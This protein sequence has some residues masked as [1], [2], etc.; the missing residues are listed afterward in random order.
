MTFTDIILKNPEIVSAVIFLLFAIPASIIDARTKKIPD[1][2]NLFGIVILLCYRFSV[3]KKEALVYIM[4][5]I[6][7]FLLLLTVR[8][9]TKK[10]LG[11]GDAK[12]GALCA[13]Y[14]GPIAVF[15]GF[16]LAAIFAGIFYA[17]KRKSPSYKKDQAFPF[18]LFL[19]AGTFISSL[20]SLI[21]YFM[22]LK[23]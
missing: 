7:A 11:L 18:A 22:K 10:G 3:D 4:S 13:S 1:P 16:I 2:L 9:V 6:M 20:P 21:L 23:G 8:L 12:Y 15:V 19:S 5:A 17:F 14:A